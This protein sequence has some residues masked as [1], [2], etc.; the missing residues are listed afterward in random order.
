M[1]IPKTPLDDAKNIL[2]VGLGGGFDVFTGLPFVYHWPDKN[3]VLT[4]YSG[5][6]SFVVRP[7][8]FEDYPEGLISDIQ[9]V[10][11]KYTIGRHG[12]KLVKSAFDKILQEH[13]IDAILAVDGGVDSLAL[14]NEED[15][16]TVL[17]DFI[18]L[19]ALSDIQIPKVIC[20]AGFGCETEED[21]NF[22]CIL[23]NM[24]KLASTDDFYGSFSLTNKM[25]EFKK[26]MNEC[27]SSWANNRRKSHIQTKIISS[28]IGKFGSKNHYSDIDPRV[29]RSTG[30]TFISL[31]SS[32]FWMFNLDAVISNN[33]V[34]KSLKNGNTFAD[35]KILLRQFMMDRELRSH[36]LIPL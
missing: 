14:G 34:I 23:E 2:L 35:S 32:I 25:P 16:G 12:P 26:Y 1:N 4:N 36:E 29:N 10:S 8:G 19:A 22:Y 30:L 13:N 6:Q 3:F 28:V 7:S 24:S 17:E 27:E 21:M 5:S 15:Y 11:A 31:L 18:T 33:L 9:N 20:C